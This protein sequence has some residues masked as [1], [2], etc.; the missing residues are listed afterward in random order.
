MK[1]KQTIFLLF[2][3]SILLFIPTNISLLAD[4]QTATI[5]SEPIS[6]ETY[7]AYYQN[8]DGSQDL[9]ILYPRSSIPVILTST[10]S[11]TIQFQSIAFDHLSA[12]ITTAYDDLYDT[13]PLSIESITEE[14]NIKY[15]TV[16]IPLDT[17]PELYNLTLIIET[18]GE[19]Y[20]T[21][22]PRA[23]SIKESMS[24]SFTFVHLTDFHIGDPRGLTENFKEIIGWKASRKTIEEI[25]LLNP[26][27]VIIS[28]DLTF[29]QLYPF[30]YSFEYPTCYEILQEFKVPTYLCPG[31]HDGYVQTFQDGLKFWENYFGPQYYSFDYHNTH[32]LSINSYDW[33]YK[34][35]LGFSYLVFNWGG[36]IQQDQLNWIENDLTSH[37]EADQTIMMMHHNPLWDTTGDSLVGNGYYNQEEILQ[38]IRSNSVDAVFDGHVHY[39]DITLDNETLYVTTTTVCSSFSGD[40]YW[41]YRLINVE[42]SIIT[43][44]NYQDP[45]YSIPSYHIN[46]IEEQPNSITI[47][48]KLVKP[49]TIQHEFTVPLDD[50]TVNTGE[51]TQIREKNG[52]AAIYVSATIDAETTETITLL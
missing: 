20:S 33:P 9:S 40:A 5:V 37:S 51:I 26:D 38:L 46:I 2:L 3:T 29:G 43:E 32:F 28:G 45:K 30:E 27:F 23:V 24:D 14:Q 8:L 16:T 21:S 18:E 10:E 1:Q 34:A 15:A 52:M 19:T 35:R 12:S 48:N 4:Q 13:I 25:N 7:P 42:D 50:Y 17:P 6:F 36:S 11:F 49:I 31:N 47:E 39:D 41:G 44:Y 22:R